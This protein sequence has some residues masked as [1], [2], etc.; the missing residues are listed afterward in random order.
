MTFR[1]TASTFTHCRQMGHW[2]VG[3]V[4]APALL[5]VCVALFPNCSTHTCRDESQLIMDSVELCCHGYLAESV[6]AG[7]GH[8]LVCGMVEKQEA[9]WALARI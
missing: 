6:A 1:D 9:D 5:A 7:H 4:T 2:N 3:L 8:R